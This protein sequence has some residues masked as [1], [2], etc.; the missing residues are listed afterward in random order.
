MLD[1]V[2]MQAGSAPNDVRVD[3]SDTIY[4]H[5][6]AT[7]RLPSHPERSAVSYPSSLHLLFGRQLRLQS[8]DGCYCAFRS[9]DFGRLRLHVHYVRHSF[10]RRHRPSGIE[11]N[12]PL[13][14]LHTERAVTVDR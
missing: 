3:P 13:N 9:T 1:L 10:A 6:L 8:R 11:V 14:P 5:G 2:V 12:N 4:G 7:C